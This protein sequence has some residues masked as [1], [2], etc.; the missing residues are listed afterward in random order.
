MS[1]AVQTLMDAAKLDDPFS[2]TREELEPLWVEA[3]N[4]RFQQCRGRIKIL[5]Q[6]A[7]KAGIDEVQ[8]LD[9]AVPLYSP[10]PHT[11][12]TPKPSS[13]RAAGTG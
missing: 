5:D 10:T 13:T 3:I 11:R 4:D 9:D 8:S 1:E 12:V 7:E 2:A 6:L